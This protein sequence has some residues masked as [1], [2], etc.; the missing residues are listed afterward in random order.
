MTVVTDHVALVERFFEQLR[1]GNLDGC[2]QCLHPDSEI[3][4]PDGIPY[5]G[6]YRGPEGFG[7]L[8][9]AVSELFEFEINSVDAHAIGDRAMSILDATFVSRTTGKRLDTTVVEIYQFTDGLI[10]FADIFPK[11]TRAIYGLT[12]DA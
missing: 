8:V 3:Y 2:L 6:R 5:G 4:E 11:D 9:A 7:Q 12:V 1:A 10:S